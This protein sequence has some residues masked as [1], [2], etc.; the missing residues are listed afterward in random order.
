VLRTTSGYAGGTKPGP[1]YRSLGDHTESV[2]VEYDP[3]RVSYREL[4][5][6]FWDSHDPASQAWSRQYRNAVFYED[7]EQRRA[8]METRAE[9]ER[10]LGR[11][12]KTDIEPAGRFYA[13]EDYHQKYSLKLHPGLWAEVRSRYPNER[14]A[15]NSTA[16]ARLNGYLAGYGVPAPEE[17]DALGLTAAGEERLRA[18]LGR[19]AR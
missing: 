18:V 2:K 6:V 8:V 15:E 11:P 17:L 16:A 13:A 14:D 4:L 10:K 7:E 1:T 12:V 19:L 9:V 5:Q 3:S